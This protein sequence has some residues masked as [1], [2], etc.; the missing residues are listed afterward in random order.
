MYVNPN[1]KVTQEHSFIVIIIFSSFE[2]YA[3]KIFI[4]FLFIFIYILII[5][6]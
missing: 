4:L 5:F 1:L 2:L 6:Q 3:K